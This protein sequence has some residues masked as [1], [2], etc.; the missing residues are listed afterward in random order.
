M[1][2]KREIALSLRE[3]A[4]EIPART[5]VSLDDLAHGF[6]LR[7][8]HIRRGILRLI[9]LGVVAKIKGDA[10]QLTGVTFDV[11]DEFLPPDPPRGTKDK[12]EKKPGEDDSRQAVVGYRKPDPI[13]SPRLP[14][15]FT[16]TTKEVAGQSIHTY[17]RKPADG[18]GDLTRAVRHDTALHKSAC[19]YFNAACDR[20]EKVIAGIPDAS[21]AHRRQAM[22]FEMICLRDAAEMIER[23]L[24]RGAGAA[25]PPAVSLR[26][27][28]A[29]AEG[30]AA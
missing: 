12:V 11:P 24:E 2:A 9:E 8:A 19:D 27:S 20:A 7:R 15:D 13:I 21:D 10:Y 16:P 14:A 17:E 28:S 4:R 25:V 5:S 18:K 29:V 3:L 26:A 22:A 23:R 1:I 30:A 6:H